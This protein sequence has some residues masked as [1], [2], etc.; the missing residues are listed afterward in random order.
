MSDD[1]LREP[2]D[3]TWEGKTMGAAAA[4]DAEQVDRLLE[5]TGGDAEAA[6]AR[7]DSDADQVGETPVRP[8][9]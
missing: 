8:D 2:E 6:E 9:E 3:P 5:E 1:A 7:F 4:D